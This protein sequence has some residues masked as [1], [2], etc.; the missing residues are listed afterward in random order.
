MI[1]ITLGYPRS[2]STMMQFLLNHAHG[3]LQIRKIHGHNLLENG[4]IGFTSKTRGVLLILRN[5]KEC[6]L[7]H[8]IRDDD[9]KDLDKLGNA[10]IQYMKAVEVFHASNVPR[11]FVYYE[12]L[13]TNLA[14][15]MTKIA[16]HFDLQMDHVINNIDTYRT[17]SMTQY[18]KVFGKSQTDGK[19]P[20]H[21]TP[22]TND[23]DF[24]WDEQMRQL[25]P[26][27]YDAYLIR[28]G[29]DK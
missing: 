19:T 17:K 5:Y 9:Q 14:G 1:L 16:K 29:A 23:Y 7:S 3:D 18:N 20:A 21:F 25:N 6:I 13:I 26:R 12:D 28:Y 4:I 8:L 15:E 10:F 2:G 11:L 24:N 22:L 27:L